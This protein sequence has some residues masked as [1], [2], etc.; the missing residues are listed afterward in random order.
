MI[1]IDNEFTL[2]QI[3]R[4]VTQQRGG[5]EQEQSPLSDLLINNQMAHQLVQAVNTI[6]ESLNKKSIMQ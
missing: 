5:G 3:Q 6:K 2:N 1:L 4:P